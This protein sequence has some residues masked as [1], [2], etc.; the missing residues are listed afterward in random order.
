[1][2]KLLGETLCGCRT[3]YFHPAHDVANTNQRTNMNQHIK[4]VAD[5]TR[6][7]VK[8]SFNPQ[9]TG[10]TYKRN[11]K[12]PVNPVRLD[13]VAVTNPNDSGIIT[14]LTLAV[15]INRTAF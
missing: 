13:P 1:M 12:D 3:W 8:S 9:N 5:K 10:L 6:A 15:L 4:K 11:H 14:L 2:H 7:L